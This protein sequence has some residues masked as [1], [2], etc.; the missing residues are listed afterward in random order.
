MCYTDNDNT[1]KETGGVWNQLCGEVFPPT[2]KGRLQPI[3]LYYRYGQSQSCDDASYF[4]GDPESKLYLLLD[5]TDHPR[6]IEDPWY[7]YDFETAWQDIE[8]GCQG[9][10]YILRE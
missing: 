10:L 5:R 1:I 6:D 7:T 9:L 4:S 8:K 2:C 3:R